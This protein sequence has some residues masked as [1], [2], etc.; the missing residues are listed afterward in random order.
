MKREDAFLMCRLFILS[1]AAL[2]GNKELVSYLVAMKANIAAK[3]LLGERPADLA[4]RM[5]HRAVLELLT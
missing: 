1:Q 4:R 5:N 2:H 3:N